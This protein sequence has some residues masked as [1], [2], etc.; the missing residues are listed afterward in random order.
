[1]SEVLLTERVPL[2]VPPDVVRAFL[3]RA[4]TLL[5][6]DHEV[7][8]LAVDEQEM[9]E[10]NEAYRHKAGPTDVLSFALNEG[11]EG[12]EQGYWLGDIVICPGVAARQAAAAGS[13]P[14]RETYWLL[15]HGLLHLL[16]Y[17][18]ERS[19]AEAQIMRDK[20][21]WLLSNLLDPT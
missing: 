6:V 7:S 15:A 11:E 1:L 13:P 12:G 16:G 8:V 17:D 9:A 14:D 5:E 2:A 4:M 3:L 20:E 10:L 19:A 21:Q 18:H